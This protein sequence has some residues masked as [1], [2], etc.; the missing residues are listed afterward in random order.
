MG[1]GVSVD[2]TTPPILLETNKSEKRL[3]QLHPRPT[4]V[5]SEQCKLGGSWDLVSKVISAL[6]GVISNYKYTVTLII[7]LV[8]KS[9][10]S[11]D[12]LSSA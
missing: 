4:I 1:A 8:K 5:H 3:S 6:I 2:W 11:H 9:R 10:D 7:T 12:T